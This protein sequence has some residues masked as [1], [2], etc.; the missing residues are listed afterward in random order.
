MAVRGQYIKKW[1]VE[2]RKKISVGKVLR[3]AGWPKPVLKRQN[4]MIF[5]G[6]Y[7]VS[8]EQRVRSVYM[9]TANI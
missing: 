8:R 2:N 9:V 6:K 1:K 5:Q 4:S 3:P 7:L